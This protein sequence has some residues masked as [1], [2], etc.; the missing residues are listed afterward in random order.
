MAKA[1]FGIELEVPL[2]HGVTCN[3][4]RNCLAEA[5][6]HE[7]VHFTGSNRRVGYHTPE[8]N[9]N[10]DKWRVASDGSLSWANG[11]E[12]VSRRR[13]TLEETK[14]AMEATRHLVDVE[15]LGS[16]SCGGHHVHIGAMHFSA[17]KRT[18]KPEK[19]EQCARYRSRGTP[20]G[21]LYCEHCED[22][23]KL[24]RTKRV[25]LLEIKVHEVYSYFQPVIDA[26]V[27]RSR[28]SS[29]N[30][31]YC[32]PVS[33]YYL[34]SL[35]GDNEHASRRKR[36]YLNDREAKA[37]LWG[38]RGVVNFGRIDEFGTIEYR[39]HQQTYHV[40]TVQNWVKLMHRLTSR[41]WVQET[42]NIDPRDFSLTVDGF[43]DFLGLGD[44]RLRAWMRRRANHFG[45]NAIARNRGINPVVGSTRRQG[46]RAVNNLR[47]AVADNPEIRD[48]IAN[49]LETGVPPQSMS[50]EEYNSQQLRESII[51]GVNNH[52]PT[53]NA[54]RTIWQFY[55]GSVSDN[56]TMNPELRQDIK[57]AIEHNLPSESYV[58]YTVQRWERLNWVS[59]ISEIIGGFEE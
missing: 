48:S 31:S 21:S 22:L 58:C 33:S 32:R 3:D 13:T 47:R 4:F 52:E 17:I 12:I 7:L 20:C 23:Q 50:T 16:T 9:Q 56:W 10:V 59:I 45:F 6:G 2:R 38:N 19:V 42:K 15:L 11:V 35:N 1:I 25:K 43:A 8:Y 41:C 29:S 57:E 53:Y 30:N 49:V 36:T 39:Q 24:V 28:R 34:E 46:T 54:V 26:L 40:A 55:R 37:P 27:S 14:K 51:L 44:N 18:Y 5:I